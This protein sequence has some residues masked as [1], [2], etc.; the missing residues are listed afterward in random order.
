M[1]TLFRVLV[2]KIITLNNNNN[3]KTQHI[4]NNKGWGMLNVYF[5]NILIFK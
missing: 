4:F 3:N 2:K 1:V 5:S